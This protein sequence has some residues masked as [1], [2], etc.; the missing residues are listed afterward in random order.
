MASA[1][2]ISIVSLVGWPPNGFRLGTLTDGEG[3]LP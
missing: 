1:L 2:L 3:S